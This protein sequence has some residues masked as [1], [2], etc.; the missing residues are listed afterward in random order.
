MWANNS[1]YR[2]KRTGT[3]NWF[4]QQSFHGSPWVDIAVCSLLNAQG[5]LLWGRNEILTYAVAGKWDVVL[6]DST[7][8]TVRCRSR[9]CSWGSG[10]GRRWNLCV[11]VWVS[12]C[13]S[14]RAALVL[15]GPCPLPCLRQVSC[16]SAVSAW[17]A[18]LDIW[19]SLVSLETYRALRCCCAS[20]LCVVL[21]FKSRPHDCM[22]GLLPAWPHLSSVVS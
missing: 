2:H 15:A 21:E 14:Q 13:G 9:R 11:C 18:G 17:I 19:K 1:V 16:S 8:E 6:C 7:Y 12:V 4:I 20:G 5:G 10:E 22:P 3:L